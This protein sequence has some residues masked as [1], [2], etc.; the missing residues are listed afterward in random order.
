MNTF[1]FRHAALVCAVTAGLQPGHS[2]S[3]DDTLETVVVRAAREPIDAA[4]SGSSVTVLEEDYLAQRQ[5]AALAEILRAVPGAAI[6]RA[7]PLGAQSQLR[8]RGAEAN[9]TLVFIDGI[10]ANDPAQNGEF[11]FAHLL[12]A[13]IEAVEIIRGPQ[14]A[15]WG[16]DA[17]AGVINVRTRRGGD[18]LGGNLYA[19]G[20]ENSWQNLGANARYGNERLR[21][22]F[23]IASVET[24]GDNIS[25]SGGEDDG[26]ENTTANGTFDWSATENLSLEGS[27]RYVDASNDYDEVD[28][29]TGLPADSNS[30]TDTEQLYGRLGA[31]LSTLDGR[32]RHSA[33]IALTDT[34]NDNRGEFSR[35]ETQGE[36]VVYT[37]QTS[38]DLADGHTLTGAYE[39]WEEDFKQRGVATDFGDPN[40]DEDIDTDSF[41]VE[42]RGQ[43]TDTLSVLA[44]ARHD[45]NS[46]FDDKTT[47]RVS[48]AWQ[49]ADATTL[50]GALGTGIKNPTFTE[51]FGFFTNFVG[52]PDLEPEESTGWEFGVDQRLLDDRLQL[53]ATWF[54][55]ELEDEING[56]FFD[57]NLGDF[58]DFTAINED[59]ESERQGLELSA[60]WLLLD[61]LTLN[62]AYTWL[63]SEDP[64]GEEEIRRAEHIASAN[65]NWDF[66]AGRA[67]LNLQVDYNGEQ[68]DFFFPPTPPF[69]ERVELDDFTLVTLT[70]SY[71]LLNNL[72]LYARIE[73]ATDEDYEEIFG[74]VAPGRTAIAGVRYSFGR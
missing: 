3:Q 5:T 33:S 50:R 60:S 72:Q 22:A 74:F 17:L 6:S 18:G 64:D 46:D 30:E 63:D 11:N 39:R 62:A 38:F 28:F 8:M 13:D 35:T 25:R 54:D 4:A 73:N 43:L 21:A 7:G 55:E 65:L 12:N 36:V 70:G 20:G 42:Y 26:Y 19:E 59:G 41:I 53:S 14:S 24:D 27:L 44:S 58:G 57:P 69:Q 16:S 52:N 61:G 37:L 40:R 31:T 66:F 49:V 9:H 56:F 1:R 32:W 67:N 51:R 15:L 68:D 48:A 29:S 47:G 34:D 71:Q 10:R 2:F 23:G 45:D